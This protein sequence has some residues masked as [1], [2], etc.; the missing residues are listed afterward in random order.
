MNGDS[1]A[2]RTYRVPSECSRYVSEIE[3]YPWNTT[4]AVQIA[5]H[6]STCNPKAIN[7]NDHH[8]GCDGSFGLMQVACLHYSK[9]QTR[10]DPE[11]NISVAYQVY[12][13]AHGSFR[14]WSTCRMI[15]GCV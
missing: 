10:N 8:K 2:P 1:A 6:E 7:W 14:D 11:T 13:A 12:L 5:V 4:I 15:K 9:G 3:K